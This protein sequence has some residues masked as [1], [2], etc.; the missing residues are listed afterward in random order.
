MN[1]S[2]RQAVLASGLGTASRAAP[3]LRRTRVRTSLWCTYEEMLD[4]QRTR[5]LLS[6]VALAVDISGPHEDT[7]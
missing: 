1:K 5:Q 7:L 3:T 2:R 4:R 6:E